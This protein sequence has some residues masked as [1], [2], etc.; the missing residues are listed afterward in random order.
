MAV[1]CNVKL[2]TVPRRVSQRQPVV[3]RGCRGLENFVET[4]CFCAE[5]IQN[6]RLKVDD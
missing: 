4:P 1:M 3:R 6:E 5:W 2:R